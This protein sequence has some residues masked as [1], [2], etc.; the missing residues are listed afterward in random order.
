M[1]HV[2]RIVS[3]E[4]HIAALR[5]LNGLPGTWQ[6]IKKSDDILF[7]LTEAHYQALVKAGVVPAN[8]KEVKSHGKKSRQKSQALTSM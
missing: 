4:Q 6:A 2:V 5:V 8:G 1:G 3:R 7:L